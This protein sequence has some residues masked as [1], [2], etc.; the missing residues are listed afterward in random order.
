MAE[1][2]RR[3]A[4]GWLDD[5]AAFASPWGFDPATIAVPVEIWHGRDD[6]A[7]PL[8]HARWLAARIPGAELHELDGGHFAPLLRLAGI[9]GGLRS[10]P[11][12]LRPRHFER[13]TMMGPR[14]VRFRTPAGEAISIRSIHRAGQA[15][16]LPEEE[17]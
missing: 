6:T 11:S 15:A 2:V 9:L 13:T 10:Y 12:R 3:S 14:L 17:I 4:D 1:C 5:S 7:S 8:A 16:R